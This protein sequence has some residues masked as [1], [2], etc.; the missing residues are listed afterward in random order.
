VYGI[1]FKLLLCAL[2]VKT[3]LG[4]DEGKWIIYGLDVIV[5]RF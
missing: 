3:D 1:L 4:R 5:I 2:D